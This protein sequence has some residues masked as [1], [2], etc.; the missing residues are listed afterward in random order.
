MWPNFHSG[1]GRPVNR[2]LLLRQ[3]LSLVRW[4][5]APPIAIT[6]VP[7][8]ADL[9]DRLPTKRWVYYCVDDFSEWPGLDSATLR[10]ME[11]RL[12]FRAE[13]LIAASEHLRERLAGM[14]RLAHVI[15][16]GVDLQFW[17]APK[18][19]TLPQ[20][21][22]LPRPLIVFWGLV[23]RRMDVAFIRTLANDL[24]EG[25]IV[26]AG[27]SQDP[28]PALAASPRVVR[29]RPL[30]FEHLPALAAN[31]AALIMPYGDLPVTQAMQP[32]K[33]K[34]YLA[35]GKPTVARDLPATRAW[36][37]CLDLADSPEAFSRLVRLRLQTG[38]PE[39]QAAARARLVG[40]SWIEKT[41]AFEYCIGA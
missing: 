41:R 40:E 17:R 6:T 11:K 32:L 5:P 7:I 19:L 38:L 14:G 24:T 35:T 20:L 33:L 27:P 39:E 9:I 28:D 23:D 31:A 25:T 3:L 2:E 22:D 16:H 37:D 29:L 13:I 12:V 4:L 15:T 30:D 21:Q 10:E 36:A 8:V 26:L 1:F 18:P 34:E